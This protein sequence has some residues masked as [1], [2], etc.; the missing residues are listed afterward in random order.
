M[1]VERE[2]IRNLDL[3]LHWLFQNGCF[4]KPC[5]AYAISTTITNDVP[6]SSA[7]NYMSMLT[8]LSL[9]LLSDD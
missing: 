8:T 9:L 1:G 6:I 4:K 5:R 3:K 2:S 7:V